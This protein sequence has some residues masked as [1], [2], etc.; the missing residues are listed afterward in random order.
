MTDKQAA[1]RQ[2]QKEAGGRMVRVRLSAEDGAILD[3]LRSAGAMS[4]EAVMREGLAMV[5]KARLR[6]REAS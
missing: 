2:R 5:A 4:G 6:E 1:Y 3:R